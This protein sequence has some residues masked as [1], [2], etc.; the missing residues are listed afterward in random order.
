MFI[1]NHKLKNDSF[2]VFQLLFGIKMQK[3]RYLNTLVGALAMASSLTYIPFIKFIPTL[4]FVV[5][6]RFSE[7][8]ST[9]KYFRAGSFEKTFIIRRHGY[10][11]FFLFDSI[12][13]QKILILAQLM[14]YSG[15]QELIQ[16]NS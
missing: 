6:N 1:K 15:F 4:D 2:I 9:K 14:T 7:F 12:Q 10:D 5:F 13:S 3:Y 8:L 11:S 16:I